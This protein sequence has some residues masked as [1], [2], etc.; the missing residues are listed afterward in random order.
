MGVRAEDIS[1]RQRRSLTGAR[2]GVP[3]VLPEAYNSDLFQKLYIE[4]IIRIPKKVGFFQ[5]QVVLD[6]KP[7]NEPQSKFSF[8]CLPG[9]RVFF[10]LL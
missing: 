6:P 2:F 7:T 9:T 3:Q 8:F 5:P 4:T 10:C 1:G